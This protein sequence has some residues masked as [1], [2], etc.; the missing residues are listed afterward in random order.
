MKKAEF[1]IILILLLCGIVS[2]YDVMWIQGQNPPDFGRSPANPTTSDVIT[3]TVPTDVYLN[4]SVARQALGGTPTLTVDTANRTVLLSFE[5]PTPSNPTSNYNPVCGLLCTF[6]PLTQGSWFF[7]TQFPGT[8]YFDDFDVTSAPSTPTISGRILTSG[9]QGINN[10]T[11][12]FLNDSGSTTTNSSGYYSKSVPYGWSGIVIPSK[13]N[14]TFSPSYRLYSNVTSNRTNQN[15][16]G[17]G[18]PAQ[19]K[20][21]V[22]FI[23]TAVKAEETSSNLGGGANFRVSVSV[24]EIINDPNNVLSGVTDVDVH[25]VVALDIRPSTFGKVYVY[26]Y[27]Q[28]G[29]GI[30]N[31][32]RV[33]AYYDPYFILRMGDVSGNGKINSNDALYIDG[34]LEGIWDLVPAQ[35]WA[36]DVDGDGDVTLD[37][38]ALITQYINGLI[39]NFPAETGGGG[40]GGTALAHPA[41]QFNSADDYFDLAYKSI[42]FTPT[43]DELLYNV[44]VEDITQLPTAYTGNTNLSLG[45]DDFKF[46]KLTGS[47]SVA[48]YG[49][50]YTGLY[51]GSNGYITFNQG[52]RDYSETL[53]EHFNLP[54]ISALFDDL[55]PTSSGG[56]VGW[57]QLSDRVA[58]TWFNVREYGSSGTNTF[59]VE[60]FFDGRIRLSWL[61]M[62]AED[63]IVGL[64][65]GLGMPSDFE[66]VDF[67]NLESVPPEPEKTDYNTEIFSSSDDMFDLSNKSITFTPNSDNSAYT[68]SIK[69]ISQLPTNASSGTNIPLV[70][71]SYVLARLTG[72]SILIF[73]QSFSQF[74]VG[75]NGYLTFT[76]GDRDY[77]ESIEDHFDTLRISALFDDLNPTAGGS[78]YAVQLSDRVA[79]TWRDIP[80]YGSSSPNTF[81]IEMFWDGRIRLSWLTIAATNGLVGLSEGLGVP[82]DFVETDLS[83]RYL[84]P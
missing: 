61:E 8:V 40:G 67:T 43:A 21:P 25:Y 28:Q 46:V 69:T 24:D 82:D 75:S 72:R 59:Q 68:G 48:L 35:L 11:V 51:V 47:A 39:D 66:E 57:R 41:E 73:G 78:V 44:S 38:E 32:D 62:A 14:Y 13:T 45:D 22:R 58:V 33:D 63:G 7:F 34:Y 56:Q 70:D 79:V 27:Y 16:I 23:G 15:Y 53:E 9:G 26:G 84:V 37:D 30:V 81:Q 36:A 17:S 18:A 77:G 65:D 3:V 29:A 20:S 5:P 52:D 19:V 10:V 1:T 12:T 42:T 74:Y 31:P 55:D 64:S 54:R 49:V 4:S 6:G 80:E 60:M 50:S 83:Q 71:D 76:E 2:G